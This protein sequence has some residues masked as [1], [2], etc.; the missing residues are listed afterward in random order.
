MS[1]QNQFP[2]TAHFKLFTPEGVQ[3][4]FGVGA[5]ARE[6]HLSR[7]VHYMERLAGLGFL[8]QMPSLEE[9]EKLEEVDAWV[10]G[11]TSKGEPCVFLYAAAHQLQFRVA[12]VYV[13]KLPELP[14][15]VNGARHW[16]GDAAPTRESAEK[17]GYL[18]VVPPF[19]VVMEPRGLTDDGKPTW[20]FARVHGA[21]PAPTATPTAAPA[22]TPAVQPGTAPAAK[23]AAGTLEVKTLAGFPP[24]PNDHAPSAADAEFAAQPPPQ[25]LRA[26]GMKGQA[27]LQFIAWSR[28]FAATFPAYAKNGQ[29]DMPHILM[30]AAAE[31]FEDVT[32]EN[33][34]QV[35]EHLT[36]CAERAVAMG[37]AA[38]GK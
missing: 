8:P 33:F 12:T 25:S 30:A 6:E 2:Y 35:C 20:R 3:I 27:M 13:E 17:K 36:A 19:R 26:A 10:L 28:T 29:P 15:K 32:V 34:A 18:Q 14:F 31:G 22:G 4:S 1:E 7:L 24:Q 21:A 37:A 16:D 9:G 11:E 38:A 23:P 5:E